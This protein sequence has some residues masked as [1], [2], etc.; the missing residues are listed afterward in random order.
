MKVK[1]EAILHT[2]SEAHIHRS[3]F[4]GARAI[5]KKVEQFQLVTRYYWY[6][7]LLLEGILSTAARSAKIIGQHKY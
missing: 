7:K 6:T 4:V 1:I 3:L 5:V 2:I